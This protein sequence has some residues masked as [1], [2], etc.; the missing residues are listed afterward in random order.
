MKILHLRLP[1]VGRAGS[2]S[3]GGIVAS[4][5]REC[6]GTGLCR[7]VFLHQQELP[8]DYSLLKKLTFLFIFALVSFM[9]FTNG[10]A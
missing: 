9:I 10:Y 6:S 4:R 7:D 5:D 2:L 3:V 1:L 8:L